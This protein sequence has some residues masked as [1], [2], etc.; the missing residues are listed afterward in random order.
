MTNGSLFRGIPGDADVAGP[1]ESI[2]CVTSV[3]SRLRRDGD[4]VAGGRAAAVAQGM[5]TSSYL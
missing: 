4:R 1:R 3:A 2:F 5:G